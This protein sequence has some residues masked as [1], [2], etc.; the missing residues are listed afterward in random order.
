[1]KLSMEKF[2]AFIDTLGISDAKFAE[3]IGVTRNALC[4]M[5]G[6]KI[7]GELKS[8]KNEEREE[9]ELSYIYA[10]RVME[11]YKIDIHYFYDNDIEVSS[12][13]IHE[14]PIVDNKRV[15][16]IENEVERMTSALDELSKKFE[17]S[18]SRNIKIITDIANDVI[19]EFISA[20]IKLDKVSKNL[21]ASNGDLRTILDISDRALI[22]YA[23]RKSLDFIQMIN[24]LD[25]ND[26]AK[27]VNVMNKVYVFKLE[28]ATYLVQIN[29][30]NNIIS[31]QNKLIPYANKI[32]GLSKEYDS[33]H[34]I[35]ES[36]HDKELE[37]LDIKLFGTF[38]D[39][40]NIMDYCNVLLVRDL[41]NNLEFKELEDSLKPVVKKIFYD[42]DDNEFAMISNPNTLERISRAIMNIMYDN[43]PIKEIY[44]EY[45]V[46]SGYL[47]KRIEEKGLGSIC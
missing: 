41:I 28:N 12:D 17:E 43:D 16:E 8:K 18:N 7:D 32:E 34:E 9:K 44:D 30:C 45:N 36:C 22:A 39:Y 3:S 19:N 13:P 6:K 38:M 21:L 10:L 40:L 14:H 11:T 42:E 2:L 29:R 37:N 25:K 35:V 33:L 31:K 24:S 26:L 1:M 5:I 15:R 46:Q 27:T 47:Q 4:K 20:T 23:K